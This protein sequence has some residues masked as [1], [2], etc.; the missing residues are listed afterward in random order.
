MKDDVGPLPDKVPRNRR[1][2]EA[3]VDVHLATWLASDTLTPGERKKLVAEKER[4]KA[5]APEIVV[6]VVCGNEGATP[7]QLKKLRE[8]LQRIKP[9]QVHQIPLP[10]KV[11]YVVKSFHVP[12][13]VHVREGMTYQQTL[14]EVVRESTV[15]VAIQKETTVQEIKVGDWSRG[16]ASAIGYARHRTT[17]VRII[18]PDG[19]EIGK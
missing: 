8:V 17:P 4:R 10:G 3:I 6:G 12:Q 5:L 2:I 13:S 16:I 1:Q 9:T 11:N 15:L 18:L 7:A 14:A 19:E